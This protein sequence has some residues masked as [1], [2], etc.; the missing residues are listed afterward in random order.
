MLSLPPA[1]PSETRPSLTICPPPSL[2]PP[3]Q[4]A[5]RHKSSHSSKLYATNKGT[6]FFDETPIFF[7]SNGDLYSSNTYSLAESDEDDG[8]G[9]A[10]TVLLKGDVH[11]AIIDV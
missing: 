11:G 6:T 9:E 1:V 4:E 3:H 5:E 8:D 7:T 10:F 2:S